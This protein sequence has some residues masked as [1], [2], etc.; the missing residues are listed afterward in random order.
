[1]EDPVEIVVRDIRARLTREHLQVMELMAQ[2]LTY[3]EIGRRLGMSRGTV[4][5]RVLEVRNQLGT[6]SR[7]EAL[8]LLLSCGV[9]T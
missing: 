6:E 2:G 9:V 3:V 1:M 8:K 5:N 4:C 7:F